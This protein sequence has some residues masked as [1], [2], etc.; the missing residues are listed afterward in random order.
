MNKRRINHSVIMHCMMMLR[1]SEK[2]RT[3]SIARTVTITYCKVD[4]FLYHHWYFFSAKMGHI[5]VQSDQSCIIM[6]HWRAA[7][8]WFFTICVASRLPTSHCNLPTSLRNIPSLKPSFSHGNDKK[9][10][11]WR[12]FYVMHTRGLVWSVCSSRQD[13][14][15]ERICGGAHSLW[16][17]HDEY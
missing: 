11:N 10:E 12:P 15:A 6:H 1:E 13:I 5:R 3:Y 8:W 2:Y 9:R 14:V 17:N 7:A 4:L 16:E